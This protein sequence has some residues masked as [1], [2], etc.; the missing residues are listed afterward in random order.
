MRVMSLFSSIGWL[1]ICRRLSGLAFAFLLSEPA[2][3]LADEH[4][5]GGHHDAKECDT[6][7]VKYA[8]HDTTLYVGDSCWLETP[9]SDN[10]STS[11]LLPSSINESDDFEYNRDDILVSCS[12]AENPR[13]LTMS[14]WNIIHTTV[15]N[16]YTGLFSY[17]IDAINPE[18]PDREGDSIYITFAVKC[19]TTP[20]K[21]AFRDTAFCEGD[22]LLLVATDQPHEGYSTLWTDLSSAAEVLYEGD[23]LLVTKP[24]T[25]AFRLYNMVNNGCPDREGDTVRAA[26]WPKP[27]AFLPQDTLEACGSRTG[28]LTFASGQPHIA[29]RWSDG[30]T[31]DTYRFAYKGDTLDK[32]FCTLY[33]ICGDTLTDSVIVRFLPP[34]AYL[35]GDSLVGC[36]GDSVLFDLEPY[37]RHLPHYN[38]LRFVW[39]LRGDTVRD[40]FPSDRDE[41]ARLWVRFPQDTGLL[42]VQVFLPDAAPDAAPACPVASDTIDLQ[43]Y[44]WPDIDFF[45]RNGDTTICHYDSIGLFLDRDSLV[46]SPDAYYIW[47]FDSVPF[48]TT[49][50]KIIYAADTGVYTVTGVNYC[51]RHSESFVLHH[52]PKERITVVMQD[53]TVCP[54]TPIAF[55]PTL[56]YGGNHYVW[57]KGGADGEGDY[58][59]DGGDDSGDYMQFRNPGEAPEDGDIDA[60][61]WDA[62]AEIWIDTPGTYTLYVMDTAGCMAHSELKITEEDC[63]PKFEAPNVFTPNG[64]GIND[65]FKLKTMEKLFEFEIRIF[66]RWGNQVLAF[67]GEPEDFEWNGKIKGNGQDAA[68]GVYFYVATYKDYKGKKK[69]QSGSVTILR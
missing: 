36:R 42:T 7:P 2:V 49:A 67:N 53:T 56:P 28:A 26:F 59:D 1:P 44:I 51:S 65:V 64:D 8:F 6:T 52:H 41:P 58:E 19:D 62:S 45:V 63:T 4:G 39:T 11:W 66:N 57:F 21:L 18:C 46:F 35:G 13:E 22:S 47:L 14:L 9:V 43:L 32:R 10:Y 24:G 20:V 31:A 50:D 23:S 61:P 12:Q 54:E 17:T 30:D 68:D 3:C 5:G 69:K 37:N 29:C 15:P 34:Y 38:D 25:Y 16:G 48:D 55:D 33:N 40:G 60:W 27:Q